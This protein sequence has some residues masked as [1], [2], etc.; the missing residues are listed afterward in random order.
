MPLIEIQV[1]PRDDVDRASISR[2]LTAAVAAAIP[3]R[4]DA[5]W[6]TWRTIDGPFARGDEV[7]TPKTA[8]A[9]GPVVHVYHH[10]APDQVDRAVEAIETVLAEALS[11]DRSSVFVTTQPV[12]IEDPAFAPEDG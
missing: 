5:V 8:A 11:I 12:A 10:R 3:C 1:L 2:A 7:S 6:T 9:F 4:R